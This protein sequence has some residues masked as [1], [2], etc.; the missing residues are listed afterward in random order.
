MA[1]MKFGS[2]PQNQ[3]ERRIA[4]GSTVT[5]TNYNGMEITVVKSDFDGRVHVHAHHNMTP[6]ELD[7]FNASIHRKYNWS[8]YDFVQVQADSC[9]DGTFDMV[10]Y[11]SYEGF[12]KKEHTVL[13]PDRYTASEFGG[14]DF[15]DVM[16][17]AEQYLE[18]PNG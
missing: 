15:S 8:M 11:A 14:M 9:A 5:K 3:F 1:M 10:A 12:G 4:M 2:N 17:A 16:N 6:N 18:S 13:R 7:Q